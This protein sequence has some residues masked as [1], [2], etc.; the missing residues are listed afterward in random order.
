MAAESGP[1]EALVPGTKRVSPAQRKPPKE[2]VLLQLVLLSLYSEPQ[3]VAS[4]PRVT[5][6]ALPSQQQE[7][8]TFLHP[9]PGLTVGQRSCVLVAVSC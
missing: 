8:G 4:K 6:G 3:R 2:R 1:G 9:P 7:E 5:S